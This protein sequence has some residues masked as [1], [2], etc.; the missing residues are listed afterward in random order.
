M[1][2]EKGLKVLLFY[3]PSAGNGLLK[4]NLD[5]IVDRFQEK[6]YLVVPVR[7][8]KGD[9]LDTVFQNMDQSQYRQVI[10]A[11]GDGTINICVNAMI[12]NNIDLPLTIMPA[13]TANDFAYYFDLPHDI[14]EMI[15]I[16]LGENFTYADVGKVN[17]KYFVNVAAMGMLVDV[18]QKTD[19][20]LK[21]T[22]GVLSYYLKGLTEVTN[23]R[24][25][26]VKL[27]SKEFTIDENMYFMLVM[28]GK[29]AGGFKRIAPHSEVDD[30]KL[31]V[32]LFKEMPIMDFAPLLINILQ[33]NHQEN[34]NVIYFKTEELTIESPED[35][36]TDVDGEKGGTFPLHFTILPKRLKISTLYS[37]MKAPI[38]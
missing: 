6:G 3:N 22:L 31:D 29:S 26:P 25:I 18:S 33:G 30:G 8:S 1:M 35:V 14:K 9:L 32:M 16:A 37:H 27:I 19:P 36:S 38:W 21:N 15:D 24:P 20:N 7:A 34:K 28:N 13:G 11:G 17:D 2:E 10:A 5:Y 4:N 23:L 12:R